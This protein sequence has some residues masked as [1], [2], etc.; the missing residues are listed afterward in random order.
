MMV[1]GRGESPSGR[2]SDP[3]KQYDGVVAT[4]ASRG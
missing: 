1:V 4:R 3:E 2:D